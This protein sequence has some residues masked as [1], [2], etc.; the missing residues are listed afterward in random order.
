MEQLHP[1]QPRPL[2]TATVSGRGEHYD[3]K[4]QRRRKYIF[5]DQADQLIREVYLSP[6]DGRGMSR[7]HLLAKRLGMPHWALKKRARELGSGA[8]EGTA[9]ERGRASDSVA[10]CVDER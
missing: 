2:C 6:R 4:L 10:I 1:S 3:D 5:S 9:L 8:H 7:I